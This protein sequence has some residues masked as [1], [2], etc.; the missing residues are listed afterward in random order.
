[1]HASI[2]IHEGT[3]APTNLLSYIIIKL[4]LVVLHVASKSE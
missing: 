3:R 2:F 1:M 4:L